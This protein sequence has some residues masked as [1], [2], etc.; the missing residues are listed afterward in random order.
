[1]VS[2]FYLVKNSLW[3]LKNNTMNF[4]ERD[5]LT[6]IL[7]EGKMCL[8]LGGALHCYYVPWEYRR[9]GALRR[10]AHEA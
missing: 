9:D 6:S 1:M 5:P 8:D 4:N 10:S 2:Q 7:L 3:S